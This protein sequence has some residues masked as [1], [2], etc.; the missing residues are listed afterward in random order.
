MTTV[1]PA[2]P[3]SS[4]AA[5]AYGFSRQQAGRR[6]ARPGVGSL[7][8]LVVAIS[9][10]GNYVVIGRPGDDAS[11]AGLPVF[12]RAA[13]ACRA[14]QG[15]KLVGQR[16][17]RGGGKSVGAAQSRVRQGSSVPCPLDAQH[18]P[19]GRD[20][21]RRPSVR[22]GSFSASNGVWTQQG[23][24]WSAARA[25]GQS[26]RATRSP[27]PPTAPPQ[28]WAGRFS[29]TPVSVPR[30]LRRARK[31]AADQYPRLRRRRLER[32]AWRDDLGDVCDLADERR[33]R[34]VERR[35]RYG[36][37]NSSSIVAQRDFDGDGKTD[38]L[39]RDRA[40]H[41]NLVYAW[42]RDRVRIGSRRHTDSFVECSGC[43]DFKRGGL[44]DLPLAGRTA[45]IS[46]SGS[47]PARRYCHPRGSA[48]CLSRG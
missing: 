13:T 7:R 17:N 26:D 33:G 20:R 32:I 4:P 3:G 2:R 46:P 27:C 24:E 44:R 30:G 10:D 41:R 6:R 25:V 8:Q 36:L 40:Q 22:P 21:R 28:S 39:W 37:P 19:R 12:G 43:R 5:T 31:A 47:W 34:F 48:M 45:A 29:T 11:S 23:N 35:N 15:N 42:R 18:P 16:R 9:A 1:T 38:L 14:Q